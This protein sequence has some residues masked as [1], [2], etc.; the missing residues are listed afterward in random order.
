MKA[1]SEELELHG[2]LMAGD[3]TKCALIVGRFLTPLIQTIG[4]SFPRVDEHLVWDVAVD[5]LLGYAAN[6][7][8][9]DPGRLT[10]LAYLRM[11]ATGNLR[12][13]LQ[14]LKRIVPS[15]NI[16]DIVELQ[17]THWNREG[18]PP[19]ADQ[20]LVDHELYEKLYAAVP[21]P[22]E[23]KVLLLMMDYEHKTEAF[24]EAMGIQHMSSEEQRMEVKRAKDR[25]KARIRRAGRNSFL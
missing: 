23:K 10:L 20:V 15:G 12:N 4:L 2:G 9:Y 22:V 6:P 11:D 21:D 7:Q 1:T 5:A 13:I 16:Q 24:A 3:M 19:V 18:S 8:R 17:P 25:I 14:R